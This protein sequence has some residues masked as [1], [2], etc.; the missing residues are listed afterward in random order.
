MNAVELTNSNEDTLLDQMWHLAADYGY[1]KEFHDGV[2]LPGPWQTLAELV[3]KIQL[4]C[5]K[6]GIT[7][8]WA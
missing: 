7:V 3:Y 5:D 1:V 2:Y 4:V 8:K 6:L